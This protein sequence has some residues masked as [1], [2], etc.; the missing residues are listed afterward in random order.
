MNAVE[1]PKVAVPQPQQP[2]PEVI[3]PKVLVVDDDRDLVATL[4][5]RLQKAG[6]VVFSAYDG[7]AGLATA[8]RERPHVVILDVMMSFHDGFEVCGELK[9]GK[10]GYK[11]KVIIV[12]AITQGTNRSE[13]DCKAE[14]GA[15]SFFSKPFE[16]KRLIEEIARLLSAK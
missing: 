9:T 2:K 11:P 6:Y 3:Q 13:A 8:Y 10:Q 15:D 5:F 16:A 4:S 12:S 1:T 7:Q 14:S